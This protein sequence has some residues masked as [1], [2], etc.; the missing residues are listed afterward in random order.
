MEH[1]PFGNDELDS[2]YKVLL[3]LL[4]VNVADG[5]RQKTDILCKNCTAPLKSGTVRMNDLVLT[6]L[7]NVEQARGIVAAIVAS[8]GGARLVFVDDRNRIVNPA[9]RQAK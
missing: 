7:G 2:Y 3:Q 8:L 4:R 5:S 9:I 6:R 1:G